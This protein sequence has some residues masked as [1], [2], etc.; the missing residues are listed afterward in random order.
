MA[1]TLSRKPYVA[2]ISIA[3]HNDLSVMREMYHTDAN[4]SAIW[5]D[6]M[7][8]HTHASYVFKD[9]YLMKDNC[10]CVDFDMRQK[11]LDECHAPP[12]AGSSGI[13][14]ATHMIKRYFFSPTIRKDMKAYVSA[15]ITCQKGKYDG[16]KTPDL[17]QPL[18]TPLQ[19]WESNAMDFIMDLP[20]TQQG[21]DAIWTIAVKKTTKAEFEDEGI[22]SRIIE[23]Y[24][25]WL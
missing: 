2:A 19:L 5:T 14:P 18:P 13:M 7:A 21:N 25:K 22:A 16:Q 1:D 17:L 9:G 10:L 15:C 8:R 20:K 11:V 24:T 6:L 4:F 3:S 12:Y 23:E